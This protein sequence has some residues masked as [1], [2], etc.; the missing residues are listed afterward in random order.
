MFLVMA[1]VEKK[2]ARDV[3]VAEDLLGFNVPINI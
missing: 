3:Q 2:T 1:E